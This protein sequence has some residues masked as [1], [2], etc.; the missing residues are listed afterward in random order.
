MNLQLREVE[1]H[2]PCSSSHT[3]QRSS[4]R[5]LIGKVGRL[6]EHKAVD[7]TVEITVVVETGMRIR[8]D[9]VVRFMT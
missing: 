9:F 4:T 1:A 2:S 7:F 3:F 8:G 6:C 5:C